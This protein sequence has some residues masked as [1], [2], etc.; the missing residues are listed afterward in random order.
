MNSDAMFKGI[1]PFIVIVVMAKQESV[2]GT[3]QAGQELSGNLSTVQFASVTEST[4]DHG[5]SQ[6]VVGEPKDSDV[7]ST[8]TGG[9]HS[10]KRFGIV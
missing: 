2:F 8:S 3:Q 6:S 4:R 5:W 1:Y 9:S 10:S 7:V